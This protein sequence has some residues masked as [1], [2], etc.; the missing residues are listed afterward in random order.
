VAATENEMTNLMQE[1]EAIR[2]HMKFLSNSLSNL[3]EQSSG[4]MEPAAQVKDRIW[5]YRWGLYDFRD[6]I[7]RHIE[8]DERIF[9]TLSGSS[10]MGKMM[11]EHEIIR[12][13]VDDALHLTDDAVENEVSPKELNKY[14]LD[15]REA[16]NKICALI[17]K[18]T[19]SEDRLLKLVQKDL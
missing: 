7:R 9:E 6:G 16:F 12:K 5:N 19:A 10:S 18:H 13:Q 3:A 14:A 2:A 1:H 8:L 17:E 15:I 11:R 4:G